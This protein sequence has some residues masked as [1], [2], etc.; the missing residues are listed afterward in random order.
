MSEEIQTV[1]S[2]LLANR[3]TDA[4]VTPE[5]IKQVIAS[6]SDTGETKS[7]QMKGF[8]IGGLKYMT[9]KT[10]DRSVYGR[11]ARSL[12][13][14]FLP[15]VAKTRAGKGGRHVCQDATGHPCGSLS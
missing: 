5:E 1:R 2:I 11:K 3:S 6:Y 13:P 14:N 7:I 15:A 8:H 10:D 9:V 4:Q 12:A